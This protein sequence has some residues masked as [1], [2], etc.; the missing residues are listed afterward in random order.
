MEFINAVKEQVFGTAKENESSNDSSSFSS[1]SLTPSLFSRNQPDPETSAHGSAKDQIHSETIAHW[2]PVSHDASDKPEVKPIN[3]GG[4]SALPSASDQSSDQSM[5]P[6]SAESGSTWMDKLGSIMGGNNNQEVMQDDRSV[7]DKLRD[8][9]MEATQPQKGMTETVKEKLESW[10][11][12]AS[13]MV[14]GNSSN[15]SGVTENMQNKMTDMKDAAQDNA[16]EM[17]DTVQEKVGDI[18]N[19]VDSMWNTSGSSSINALPDKSLPIVKH[20]AT[21]DIPDPNFIQNA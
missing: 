20:D 6:S 10:S 7:M 2:E 4:H 1:T 5:N 3:T 17:K 8:A 18:K 16:V 19:K 11:Q 9:H 14:S 21:A 12:N 15:E 13:N